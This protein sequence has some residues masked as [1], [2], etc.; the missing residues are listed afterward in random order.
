[1]PLVI[2]L[3]PELEAGLR[4]MSAEERLSQAELV[5]RLIRERLVHRASR[6]TAFEIAEALGVVGMDADPRT[7]VAKNHSRYVKRAVRG[8]RSA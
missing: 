6:K 7:D 5:R 4:R 3:D 1:M 8:K 2:R